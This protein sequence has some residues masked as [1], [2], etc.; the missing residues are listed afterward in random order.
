MHHMGIIR[1]PSKSNLSYMNAHFDPLLFRDLYVWLLDTLWQKQTHLRSVLRM[2]KRKVLLMD[3]TVI[4]L[5]LLVFDLAR[6]RRSAKGEVKLHTILDYDG[7]IPS[8]VHITDGKTHESTIAT[9]L[10]FPKG[11]VVVVDRC[12]VDYTWM[13]VLDSKVC[14]FVIRSKSN[15]KYT[16]LK[17]WQSD[18]LKKSGVIED[19]VIALDGVSAAQYVDKK[20]R[21]VR[22]WDSIKNV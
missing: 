20:M 8:F 16:V 6:F 4:L 1:V 14:F 9:T 21:L 19:Q 15:M 11:C 5:C 12:Y 2:L 22:I 7:C 13:N 3:A 10:S 17:S 18:E